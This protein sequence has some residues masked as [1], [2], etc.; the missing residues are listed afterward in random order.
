MLVLTDQLEEQAALYASGALTAMERT[1]F[2]LLLRFHD[3]LRSLVRSLESATVAAILATQPRGLPPSPAFKARLLGM[4]DH[5]PQQSVEE[6]FVMADPNGFVQWINP[7]FTAMCGYELD[8]LKG[9]K[10]GPILQGE[11]T[12][13]IA[14]ARVREAVHAR[15]PCT[16]ALINYHRDGRPYWVSINL[17]PIHAADGQLLW[18][19]AREL[20]LVERPI[21]A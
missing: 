18:F 3:E 19:V 14:A 16:E 1:Q 10:L 20:E 5:R 6:G 21:A 9:R 13:R 11:L 7:A 8:E 12:D 17:T 4:I 2:E 15:R